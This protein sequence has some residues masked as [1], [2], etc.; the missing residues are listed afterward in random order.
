MIQ[1]EQQAVLTFPCTF[2]FKVMGLSSGSF[3]TEMVV[4]ARKHVPDLGEGAVTSKPSKNGKYTAVTITFT[5]QSRE[6]LDNLYLEV[7]THPD[8][9]M[10]L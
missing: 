10:V 7:N 3:E 5:A 4:I 6:Q 1:E 8:V 9:R 2:P